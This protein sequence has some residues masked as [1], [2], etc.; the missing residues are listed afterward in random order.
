MIRQGMGARSSCAPLSL[1]K[2]HRRYCARL[3]GLLA[4]A[5]LG[6]CA[7]GPFA[8]ITPS[9]TADADAFAIAFLDQMQARSFA[10]GREFCGFFGRDAAGKVRATP[11]QMGH[12]ERCVPGDEPDD[13]KPFASYHS[14]GAFNP[15]IDSEVPSAFDLVADREEGLQGYI[16]TPGGRVWHS[17]QGRARLLCGPGCIASDPAYDPASHPPIAANYTA[18]ELRRRERGL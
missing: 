16:S 15:A 11:P 7:P 14:H 10:T 1:P 2:R 4:A 17:A 13:F 3:A 8:P 18:D 12:R 5:L 9:R 6:G